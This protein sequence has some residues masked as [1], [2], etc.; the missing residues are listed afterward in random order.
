MKEMKRKEEKSPQIRVWMKQWHRGG[1]R[2]KLLTPER[3]YWYM[4][5]LTGLHC[6]K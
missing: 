1:K 5:F 2:K 3:S 6:T 4:L